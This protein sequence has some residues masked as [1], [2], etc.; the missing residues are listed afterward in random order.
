MRPEH[1]G[2]EREAGIKYV[3]TWWER[4]GGSAADY[5]QAQKRVLGLF[6]QW[7]MPQAL[8][9]H[10]FLVRVGV[11]GGYAV[12]ETDDPAVLHKTATASA[13]FRF[14]VEPVLDIMDAVAAEWEAIRGRDT[15]G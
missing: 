1:T 6:Q 14:R 11:F 3:V 8:T 10:Q 5:E 13:A 4:P 7:R 12:V 15:V 2:A 9:F